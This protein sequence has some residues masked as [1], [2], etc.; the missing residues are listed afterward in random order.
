MS[1]RTGRLRLA[2]A[3]ST[4]ALL[5]AG[6]GGNAAEKQSSPPTK[7]QTT[8]PTQSQ[9]AAPAEKQ[10]EKPGATTSK[11]PFV[12]TSAGTRSATPGWRSVFADDFD[13]TSLD[14]QKW[15]TRLQ[16]NVASRQCATPGTSLTKVRDGQAVLGVKQVGK[17]SKKC[18][19]GVWKNAMIG[20]GEVTEPGF[21]TTY[22]LFAARVKFQKGDG[23]HGSFWLQ[24]SGPDAAEIDIAEY[25]GD[26]HADGGTT[27][28]IHRT[29]ANGELVTVGGRRPEVP[30]AL[31]KGQ[32]P[33]SGWHVW[34]VAWSPKGYVFRVDDHVTM[35]TSRSKAS[36]KEFMVLSLLTSDFELPYLDNTKSKMHVDW[37][38]VWKRD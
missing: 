38:R 32:T 21:N 25:F 3:V 14:R 9:T 27:N 13:G 20:T 12:N 22:G 18:P 31:G 17:K 15:R 30:A 35:R 7:T 26:G 24:G 36:A 29:N 28:F 5:L 4:L 23:Q 16:P 2:A 10:T 19:H 8:S 34:S 6:C 11:L 33:A 37:V 1:G